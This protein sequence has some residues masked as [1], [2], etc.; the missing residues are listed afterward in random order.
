MTE[1]V[2]LIVNPVATRVH[3]RLQAR[4]VATLEPL[5][6]QDVLTTTPGTRA[7][8]LATAAV[9][10]GAT[11]VAVLGGDGTVNEVATTLAGTSAVLLPFAGGSTNV[12]ARAMGWPHPAAAALPLVGSALIRGSVRD[13][14]LGLIRTPTLERVFLV[15]MGM[16]VDANTVARIENRPRL[17]HVLRQVGFGLVAVAEAVR[18]VGRPPCLVLR[19][20][21]DPPVTVASA[22]VATG[23]PYAYFGPR[24]LDLTPG[25]GF[26]GRLRWLGIATGGPRQ[27]GVVLQGGLRGGA[28]I[29]RDGILDGW[30]Q[31][32]ALEATHPVAVQADGE[33]LGSHAEVTVT[34]GPTLRVLVPPA[35]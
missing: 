35:N 3:P 33:P 8:T 7:E 27:L 21:D 4:V 18:A 32:V 25:A 19:A 34:P 5:G 23:A 31:R 2:A 16:G 24:P 26:D 11:L 6:L 1:R 10:R 28:H 22:V 29:G 20:D 15:N 30:A 12:F 14:S 13:V 17:K 9:D